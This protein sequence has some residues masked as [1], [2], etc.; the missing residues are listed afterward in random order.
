MAKYYLPSD[1]INPDTIY[2]SGAVVC[3]S[4][5]EVRRL[6]REWGTDLL[7]Q[8]REASRQDIRDYGTYDNLRTADTA[9]IVAYI[10]AFDEWDSDQYEALAELADRAGIDTDDYRDESGEM[11]GA[12]NL[13][14]AIEEALGV[15]LG[16]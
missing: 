8:M 7:A 13:V 6:S 4:E 2:G 12:H 14:A 5:D 16:A 11:D 1:S 10:N 15:D 9:D 3:I